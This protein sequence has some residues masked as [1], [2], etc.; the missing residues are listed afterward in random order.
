MKKSLPS[1]ARP[2]AAAFVTQAM[3][4]SVIAAVS[5]G[6]LLNDMMQ[7]LLLSIYPILKSSYALSFAQLGWLTLAYQLTA[8]LL[9]PVAGW[10]A[11]RRAVPYSLPAGTLF[12]ATGVMILAI[13]H[14]YALLLIGACLLGVGSS[15][16]H[17]ESSRVTRL[18]AGD[19]PGLAQSLFQVGGNAG[20][21][22][23]PLCAAIVVTRWGQRSLLAFAAV[24]L[25]SAVALWHVGGWYKHRLA[26]KPRAVVVGSAPAGGLSRRLRVRGI[27]ILLVLIFSKYAYT[28]TL[29]SYYTFYLI[30]RF[31]LSLSE[32]Q[33]RLFVFLAALA[34]GTLLG[35]PLGDRFGRD[36]VIRFS[37]FGALPL[38]LLLPYANLYWNGPLTVAIGLVMA[39]SFPAIVVFGQELLPGRVGT[40][41]GLLFGFAFGAASLSAALMGR[42][43]DAV[44]VGP[45]YAIGAF[46]PL[47]GAVT[48]F[49]PNPE[50]GPEHGVSRRVSAF[51]TSRRVSK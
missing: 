48:L 25:L 21:A 51:A 8:S 17:P 10:Y 27:W 9:Q 49:L 2:S 18:A 43:A 3:A 40:V 45:V 32:A 35:G 50:A 39:A 42:V 29:T 34:C 37:V 15:V 14:A 33:V 44:G 12:T 36:R 30:D 46:L 16:F 41:S 11:D 31:H 47:L 19:Q 5:F 22:L 7:S 28:A 13:G 23:G 6:H 1:L 20:S 4:S 24:T 26:M 38:T